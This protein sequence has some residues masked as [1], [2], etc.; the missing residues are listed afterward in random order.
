MSEAVRYA[1]SDG[2]SIAYVDFPGGPAEV[3]F[4]RGF[5]SNV[6][7]TS[8]A[9]WWPEIRRFARVV[10][11]DKRGVGLSER[12]VGIPDLETR[13]DDVRAVMDAVELERAHLL[14]V[15]EG[16]PMSILF[17]ATYP[18][19][20]QSLTL[21]A[22]FAR[23]VRGDDHPWM[24]TV[25]ERVEQTKLVEEHWG[26]GFVLGAFLPKE[27]RTADLIAQLA[28]M[29]VE[30]AS[31]KAAVQ[32]IQMDMSIDVR[33]ILPS[34]NVPTLVAHSM[35]DQLVPVDCA[36]YLADR[37]PG[38]KLLLDE[39]GGHSTLQPGRL[40]WVDAF[41]ELVTGHRAAPR[42]DRV[43]ATVLFTDIVSSTELASDRGD[44]AWRETLDR[45]D[46]A[47]RRE[48]ETYR[49]VLVKSTGDGVLA[50]FDGPGR[51]VACARA[52]TQAVAGLGMRIRSGAHTGEI[53]LRGDDIGG[54]A[55]HIA[56]RVANLARPGEVLVS[57]TIKDLTAGSGLTFEDR[58]EHLLKGVPDPWQLYAVLP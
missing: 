35:G 50:R 22:T 7:H 30:S 13:M 51:A 52:I 10:T 43:L 44:A 3:V 40:P 25:E 58:G 19:R 18:E 31:P 55:V 36:R 42:L 57:R 16:G 9:S 32:L 26:S 34:I 29:E 27:E 1:R 28:E 4:I 56:S 47:V 6:T 39:V 24:P 17:A 5:A 14:G 49:G 45:H 53:E 38:A 20:V 48:V 12:S 46:S 33:S 23:F 2:V 54:I 21:L 41:E 15:S 8:R 11:F 37:I